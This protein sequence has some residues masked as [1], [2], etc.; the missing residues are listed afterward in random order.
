[1]GNPS[2]FISFLGNIAPVVGSLFGPIGTA[3]GAGLSGL[4]GMIGGQRAAA[5]AE[6]KALDAVSAMNQ[7]TGGLTQQLGTRG[8]VANM[9]ADAVRQAGGQLGAAGLYGSSIGSGVVGGVLSDVLSKV[10]PAQANALLDAT[11]LQLTP[12]QNLF[13]FYQQGAQAAANTGGP[14]YSFLGELLPYLPGFNKV[15]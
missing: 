1:M 6:N 3:L 8:I 14:D 13:G 5:A 7:I 11:R 12:Y 10:Y 2:G 15:G 9:A 4:L